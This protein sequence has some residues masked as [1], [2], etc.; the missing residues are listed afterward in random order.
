LDK[1]G[2]Q[3]IWVDFPPSSNEN[4]FFFAPWRKRAIL[5]VAVFFTAMT[6]ANASKSISIRLSRRVG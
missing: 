2:K 3:V 1:K 4:P 6:A 5:S